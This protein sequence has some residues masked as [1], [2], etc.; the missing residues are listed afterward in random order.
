MSTPNVPACIDNNTSFDAP[1]QRPCTVDMLSCTSVALQQQDLH[2]AA[3]GIHQLPHWGTAEQDYC[4]REAFT[5]PSQHRM[6]HADNFNPA[7]LWV[8]RPP[9]PKP[10]AAWLGLAGLACLAW[11]MRLA[12]RQD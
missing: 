5:H 2:N 9:V 12:A 10:A 6:I 11:H 7:T 4:V 3:L 1:K 8:S